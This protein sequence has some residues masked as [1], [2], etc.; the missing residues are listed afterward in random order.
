ML[1][2][3]RQEARTMPSPSWEAGLLQRTGGSH[4][5]RPG[6]RVA[7]DKC[8]CLLKVSF[9]NDSFGERAVQTGSLNLTYL[10]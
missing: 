1:D 2:P 3:S 10:T 6:G 7:S 8:S 9:H 4:R 5:G